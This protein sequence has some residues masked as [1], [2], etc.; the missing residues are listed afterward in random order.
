MTRW[1]SASVGTILW[2]DWEDGYVAFHRAS[3]T[4]HFLNESSKALLEDLLQTPKDAQAVADAFAN[5]GMEHPQHL[6]EVTDML[7]RF[8]ELGLIRRA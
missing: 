2:A 4:T 8:E 1:R 5:P 3:G 7:E 6:G